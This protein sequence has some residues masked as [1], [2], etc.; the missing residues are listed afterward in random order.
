MIQHS[1]TKKGYLRLKALLKN[2][3]VAAWPYY[4]LPE[5]TTL[6]YIVLQINHWLSKSM[7]DYRGHLLLESVCV[8]LEFQLR[9]ECFP[10]PV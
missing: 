5:P 2:S 8:T 6:S 1:W 9:T 10:S 3:K 4:S 7:Q